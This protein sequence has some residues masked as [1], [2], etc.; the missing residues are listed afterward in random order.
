MKEWNEVK[1]KFRAFENELPWQPQYTSEVQVR[2]WQLITRWTDKLNKNIR[3]YK[4]YINYQKS[5]RNFF[6]ICRCPQLEQIVKKIKTY[7]ERGRVQLPPCHIKVSNEIWLK[8]IDLKLVLLCNTDKSGTWL[9]T[10]YK[11]RGNTYYKQNN[12]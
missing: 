2:G 3:M 5:N 4:K 1:K 10:C 9:K 8:T 6:K 7:S 11:K 12:N